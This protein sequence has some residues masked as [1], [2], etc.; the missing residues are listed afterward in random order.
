MYQLRALIYLAGLYIYISKGKKLEYTINYS[1]LAAESVCNFHAV[2][3]SALC[4]KLV[5][6]NIFWLINRP[7]VYGLVCATLSSW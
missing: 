4:S 1:L 6:G 3:L 7:W 5:N 2:K